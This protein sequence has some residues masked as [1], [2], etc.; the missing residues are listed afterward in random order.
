MPGQTEASRWLSSLMSLATG[1]VDRRQH[2]ARWRRVRMGA[3]MT[4]YM[5]MNPRSTVMKRICVQSQAA[6]WES[7]VPSLKSTY[8]VRVFVRYPLCTCWC[9]VIRCIIGQARQAL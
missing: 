2:A 7:G 5:G 9:T 4:P 8:V 1:M 6:I 3:V